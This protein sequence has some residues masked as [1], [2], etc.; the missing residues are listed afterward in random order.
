VGVYDPGGGAEDGGVC[1]DVG[2]QLVD[3]ISVDELQVSGPAFPDVL[4]DLF[5]LLDFCFAICDYYLPQALV[6]DPVLPTDLI[7]Q[8]V[9]LD[10]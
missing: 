5:Q 8:G 2:L 3:A 9:G 6:G 1:L 7:D 4:E 10:A